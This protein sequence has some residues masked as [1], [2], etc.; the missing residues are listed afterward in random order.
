MKCPSCGSEDTRKYS[1]IY[2]QGTHVSEAK[3]HTAGAATII[4]AAPGAPGPYYGSYSGITTETRNTQ[5]H[6]A[7]KCSPPT[8]R[9]P[10]KEFFT[11]IWMA[12]VTMFIASI[13]L[14]IVD[15]V[16]DNFP[17]SRLAGSTENFVLMLG[18]GF[19]FAAVIGAV[20]GVKRFKTGASYNAHVYPG[21]L[22]AWRKSRLCME[23]G[24]SYQV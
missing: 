22:D 20:V 15:E 13:L 6:L 19:I 21:K 12:A 3:V 24:T 11:S 5:S 7:A 8:R 23:C 9:K 17:I 18:M 1:V 4:S 10:V 16:A 14:I 2:E